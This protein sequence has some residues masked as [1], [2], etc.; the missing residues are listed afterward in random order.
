MQ[1]PVPS[2]LGRVNLEALKPSDQV[3]DVVLGKIWDEESQLGCQSLVRQGRLRL[4]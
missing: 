3:A 4:G 2:P 1:D